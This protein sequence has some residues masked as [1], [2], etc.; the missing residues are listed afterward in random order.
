MKFAK[1]VIVAMTFAVAC[2][3]CVSDT[4]MLLDGAI[5]SGTVTSFGPKGFEVTLPDGTSRQ[6]PTAIVFLVDFA[7]AEDNPTIP[8]RPDSSTAQKSKPRTPHRDSFPTPKELA[9]AATKA[10]LTADIP[11]RRSRIGNDFLAIYRN[12]NG[13]S[14]NFVSSAQLGGNPAT[15]YNEVNC[16]L[17]GPTEDRVDKIT[18]EAECSNEARSHLENTLKIF[19]GVLKEIDTELPADALN[20]LGAAMERPQMIGRW[21]VEAKIHNAGADIVATLKR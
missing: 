6:V 20:R 8:A 12:F 11:W 21:R 19:V 10:R 15:G 5:V 4:I 2:P 1:A 18:V 17:E 9:A 16:M 7:R 14:G 3:D 13:P